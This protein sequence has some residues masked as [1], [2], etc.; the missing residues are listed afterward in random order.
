MKL[1]KIELRVFFDPLSNTKTCIKKGSTALKIFSPVNTSAITHLYRFVMAELLITKYLGFIKDF[2]SLTREN[3]HPFGAFSIETDL[4]LFKLAI[5]EFFLLKFC[6]TQK[7][8][9][10]TYLKIS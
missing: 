2:L 9:S 10:E 6:K 5:C 4:F 1:R 8:F 7:A 3:I